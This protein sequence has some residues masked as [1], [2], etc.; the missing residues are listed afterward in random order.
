[1]QTE[2]LCILACRSSRINVQ[3]RARC[4]TAR[5][6]HRQVRQEGVSGLQL[7]H[8]ILVDRGTLLLCVGAG[9]NVLVFSRFEIA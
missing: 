7:G 9:A 3:Q 5:P 6:K 2:P 4:T 1:V 8:K